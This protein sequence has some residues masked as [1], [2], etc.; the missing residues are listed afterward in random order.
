ATKFVTGDVLALP[1]PDATFDT[2]VSLETIEH[3]AT[4]AQ[5][6]AEFARV[7][8]PD[9]ILLGSVPQ[10]EFEAK[11]IEAYGPNEFHKSKFTLAELKAMVRAYFPT[12][13]LWNC[14]LSVASVVAPLGSAEPRKTPA[15]HTIEAD[16][17]WGTPLGSLLFAASRSARARLPEMRT[18]RIFPAVSVVEHELTTLAPR[19]LAIRNQTRMIDE[20]DLL[21]RRTESLLEARRAE[22]EAQARLIADRDV[23]IARQ[24]RMIEERD[25]LIHE[26]EARIE[27][28]RRENEAQAGLVADRDAAIARQTEMIDERDRVIREN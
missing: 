23:A 2:V 26:I 28:R 19:D 16:A 20:R 14:W 13:E 4:P 17:P 27:E 12:L 1:F 10:A 5:A 22:N 11:C 9:G 24:T 21:I 18:T 15:Q 3:L 25:G 7:L 6:L 8:K